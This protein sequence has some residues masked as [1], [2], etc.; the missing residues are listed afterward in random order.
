MS[1]VLVIQEK[2]LNTVVVL[3]K[4]NKEIAKIKLPDLNTN[5]LNSAILVDSLYAG[6]I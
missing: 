1:L 4:N 6:I 3:Y 2:N 5:K